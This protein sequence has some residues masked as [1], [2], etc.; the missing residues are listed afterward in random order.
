MDVMLGI[1]VGTTSTKAVS[2]D[3]EGGE[4]GPGQRSYPLLEPNP[5]RRSRTRNR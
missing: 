2:V 3:A 5:A 4:H 1:D